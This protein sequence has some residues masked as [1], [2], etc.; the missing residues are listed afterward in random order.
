MPRSNGRRR[1]ATT[2][3]RGWAH[4]KNHFTAY[5]LV[6]IYPFLICTPAKSE[7]IK[8]IAKRLEVSSSVLC[9]L[10]NLSEAAEVDKVS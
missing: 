3:G 9:R 4:Q 2:P 1:R 10:N 7:P 8:A 5:D 6:D